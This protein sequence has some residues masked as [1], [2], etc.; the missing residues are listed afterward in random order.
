VGA[1]WRPTGFMLRGR[2]GKLL[3][4]YPASTSGGEVMARIPLW[5]RYARLFGPDPA[6]DV[7]DE[8]RFH[9]EAKIDDLVAQGWDREEARGGLSGSL[10]IS[11]QCDRRASI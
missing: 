8:L 3:K 11:R 7:N 4:R 10:A 6:A 1:F 2:V 9:L 5:R